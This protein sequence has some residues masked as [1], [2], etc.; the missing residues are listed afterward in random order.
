[1]LRST[2]RNPMRR[3]N[4]V[5]A[6]IL[7]S[8]AA[9]L[10]TGC[11]QDPQRCVDENNRVVDPSFCQN[12]QPGQ[13]HTGAVYENNGGYYNHGIFYPHIFRYYYGGAGGA[14]GSF[15]SGGSFAPTP[16]HSY[17]VGGTTRGGF[18]HLFSGGEGHGFGGGE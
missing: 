17:S 16:G 5:L 6:P 15:I 8:A 4:F 2:L 18:G 13:A 3:S 14:I 10:L 1:M 9:T 11:H 7:A 12:L